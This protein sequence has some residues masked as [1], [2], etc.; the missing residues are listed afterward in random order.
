LFGDNLSSLLMNNFYFTLVINAKK[1][2]KNY[3]KQLRKFG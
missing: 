2:S 1:F 3:I